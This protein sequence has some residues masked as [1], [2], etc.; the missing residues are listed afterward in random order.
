MFIFITTIKTFIHFAMFTNYTKKELSLI[1]KLENI[2]LKFLLDFFRKSSIIRS[3]KIKGGSY[4]DE[5][6]II[7]YFSTGW[8]TSWMYTYRK[9]CSRR[10]RSWSCCGSYA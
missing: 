4:K 10:C 3:T 7:S 8:S 6:N 1:S 9:N 5:K 2:F